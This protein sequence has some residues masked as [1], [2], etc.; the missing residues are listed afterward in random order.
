MI[1]LYTLCCVRDIIKFIMGSSSSKGEVNAKPTPNTPEAPKTAAK[2][3]T[4]PMPPLQLVP[5]ITE[6]VND[7]ATS[8]V[9][10]EEA[11]DS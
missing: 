5:P 10:K 6:I 2:P 8:S 7:E 3:Q 11:E 9:T 1:F 4:D